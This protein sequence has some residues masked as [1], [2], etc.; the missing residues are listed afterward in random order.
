MGPLLDIPSTTE[1]WLGMTKR[2]WEEPWAFQVCSYF[3][4]TLVS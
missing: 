3:P 4:W 2:L 1:S